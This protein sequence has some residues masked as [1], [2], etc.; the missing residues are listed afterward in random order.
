ML[1]EIR[2]PDAARY[3]AALSLPPSSAA[4]LLGKGT[5]LLA[6]MN[7]EDAFATYDEAVAQGA[8]SPAL[9]VN[10]GL[11]AS[12]LG[13]YYDALEACDRALALTPHEW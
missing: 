9:W 11:A 3:A 1:R 5:A 12:H 8:N 7:Y 13:R 2:H 10:R 4:G 6:L